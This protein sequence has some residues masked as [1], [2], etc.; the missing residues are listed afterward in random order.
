MSDISDVAACCESSRFDEP[1]GHLVR[2]TV[3]QHNLY[4]YAKQKR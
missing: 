1:M 4:Y 3:K 2:A